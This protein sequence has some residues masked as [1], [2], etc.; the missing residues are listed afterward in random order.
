VDANLRVVYAVEGY[1]ANVA[2]AVIRDRSDMM[3]YPGEY[4]PRDSTDGREDCLFS[5][6]AF[7]PSDCCCP[8]FKGASGRHPLLRLASGRYNSYCYVKHAHVSQTLLASL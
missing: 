3:R 4:F 6:V 1:G 2:D 7:T 5:D 8:M